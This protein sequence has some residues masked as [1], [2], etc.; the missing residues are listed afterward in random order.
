MLSTI[1][2]AIPYHHYHL[3]RTDLAPINPLLIHQSS[4]YP[5]TLHTSLSQR[6]EHIYHLSILPRYQNLAYNSSEASR[7][8]PVRTL[9]Q[10]LSLPLYLS[11]N[12]ILCLHPVSLPPF[13]QPFL[14][15]SIF[16]HVCYYTHLM[17]P[18]SHHTVLSSTNNFPSVNTP[19]NGINL[20]FVSWK[21]HAQLA[22]FHIPNLQCRVF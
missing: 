14:C 16:H 20:V 1:D 15:L 7:L 4:A 11:V 19:I 18:E 17:C 12:R 21:I 9:L 22:R 8:T 5:S 3:L 10:S 13:L 2:L 6:H